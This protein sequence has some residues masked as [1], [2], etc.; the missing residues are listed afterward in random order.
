MNI[1]AR[2]NL[3]RGNLTLENN[4]FS[5]ENVACENSVEAERHSATAREAVVRKDLVRS[6]LV[7]NDLVRFSYGVIVVRF[8][9]F[10]RTLIKFQVSDVRLYKEGVT[11]L[12][13]AY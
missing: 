12:L 5:L 3:N 4:D 9:V 6:D 11:K 8:C 10:E 13:H 1:F 7:R 2:E